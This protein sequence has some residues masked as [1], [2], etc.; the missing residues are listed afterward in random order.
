MTETEKE[1]GHHLYIFIKKKNN[2]LLS[3]MQDNSAFTQ[4]WHVNCPFNCPITLS[5]YKH[6]VYTMMITNFVQEFWYSFD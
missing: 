2:S 4:A 1:T 5:N 3:K 6:D